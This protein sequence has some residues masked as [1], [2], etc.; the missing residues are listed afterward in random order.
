MKW[1]TQDQVPDAFGPKNFDATQAN[2]AITRYVP[3]TSWASASTIWPNASGNRRSRPSSGMGTYAHELTHNLGIADNYNN[4]FGT[5]LQRA[6]TGPWDMMSRGSF[7]GPGGTH[8]R[9][10]DVARGAQQTSATRPS[11][12]SSRRTSCSRS[13]AAGW[14]SP[15]WSWPTS[16]RVRST[17]ARPERR[18]GQPRRRRQGAALHGGDQPAVRRRRP[19]RHHRRGHQRLQQLPRRG[20]PADRLRLL[21]SEP[22][23]DPRSQDVR[24][25]DLRPFT[26]FIWMID[27]HP[28]D[29]NMVD[30]VAADGTVNKVT[31]A[32]Q[33]QLDDASFNAGL[34]SGSSYEYEDT[35][36]G[37]ASTSS[38]CTRTQRRPAL[39]DRRAVAGRQRPA[40][41]RRGARRRARHDRR[42]RPAG[43]HVHA[44]EHGRRRGDRSRPCTR[45]TSPPTS[46][47]TSTG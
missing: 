33:R 39:H 25:L 24:A 30:F 4:P 16:P 47:A 11:S 3:W 20:R 21:R 36:T 23:R 1:A 31:I 14:R 41:P 28:D 27:A 8:A 6:A 44:Q 18:P 35:A 19:Q 10:H 38:I 32:D 17:L 29:I 42:R 9:Y 2:W 37:C 22:R 40:D 26:C 43:L 5:T 13:T 45:R 12:V 15:A 46:R 7:G 34:N